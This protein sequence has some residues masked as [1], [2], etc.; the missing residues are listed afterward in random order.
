MFVTSFVELPEE[1]GRKPDVFALISEDDDGDTA[2]LVDGTDV[3]APVT[4]ELSEFAFFHMNASL[5]HCM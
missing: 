4:V 1:M 5:L 3:V 2:E